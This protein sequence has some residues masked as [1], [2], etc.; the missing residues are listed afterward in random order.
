MDEAAKQRVRDF[1][2]VLREAA[3]LARPGTG[4]SMKFMFGGAGFFADG[5]MFAGAFG[6]ET[7]ALKLPPDARGDL[8]ALGGSPITT[9]DI[10]IPK[11][12]EVPPPFM[13]DMTALVPFVETSIDYALRTASRTASRKRKPRATT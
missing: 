12:A 13:D 2:H 9:P 3:E 10:W 4:F 8:L 6:G 5:V 7:F 1:E 11:Y